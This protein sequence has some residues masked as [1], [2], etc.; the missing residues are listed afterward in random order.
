MHI[1]ECEMSLNETR[2]FKQTILK[3]REAMLYIREVTQD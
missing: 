2:L 1:S 3:D